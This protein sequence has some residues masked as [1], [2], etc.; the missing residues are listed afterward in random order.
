MAKQNLTHPE[1]LDEVHAVDVTDEIKEFVSTTSKDIEQERT[2]RS[3]WERRLDRLR[4]LRYGYR[5]AKTIPWIDSANYSIPLI[6]AHINRIKPAYVNL[7]YGVSPI[8]SFVPF[9]AEDVEPA[10]K[11]EVLFDW[12]M[13][14]KVRMFD[15]Y[16]IGCD[17]ELEQGSVVYKITWNYSTRTYQEEFDV[18]DLDRQTIEAL[19][20]KRVTNDMLAV[21]MIEERGIDTDFEENIEEVKKAV[22]SFREGEKQIA[23]T[24]IEIENDQPEVKAC[25]VRE[26][27]VVPVD[28]TELQNA[29]FIDQPFWLTTNQVKQAM[30]VEKY[31]EYDDETIKGWGR[32][33]KKYHG[34][35][36]EKSELSDAQ[37]DL[38]LFHETCVWY[39]INGTGIKEKCVTTWPDNNPTD[40]L[41]F[42]E[43]PYDHGLFP[44]EQVRREF[45][46]P[47]FYSP[48]GIADLDE[49]YQ[50]GI[51]NSINQAE[52]NGTI[53]NKPVIVAR[54]NLVTN[55]ANRS[56][57]PG[58]FVETN[59][60]PSGY[61]IR[62]GANA[63][64]L[65]LF[66]FAQYL[67]GWSDQ[68]L[69]N[70]GSG[71][72]SPTDLPGS[73]GGGKK[74][75]KEIDLTAALQGQMQSLDVQ[76]LQ[77]QMCKVFYQIDALYQHH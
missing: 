10:K 47:S 64:Q 63:S 27:I 21:I 20:D 8:A 74:T 62:Q 65:P 15:Q 72:S 3:R 39:D 24:L 41:R 77:E 46:D 57:T 38:I 56:Y 32:T 30:N 50:V 75:A 4:D 7:L 29:R 37:D 69:G 12:Q 22:K 25:S 26:D 11:K 34:E 9:G 54:K 55:I 36:R 58:E 45:N 49:D 2:N 73:G 43:V 67:K 70:V 31:I 61:Q 40:V 76:I 44:Y 16:C 52:D 59:G 53:I 5:K 35:P 60:D 6:D 14:T 66:Q 68:R 51:T 33:N 1:G 23:L 18:E 17:K 13:R 28:T 71:L 42:I 48:R 19:S